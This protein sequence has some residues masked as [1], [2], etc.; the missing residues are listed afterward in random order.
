MS[1]CK[2]G[3]VEFN[4]VSDEIPNV[5]NEITDRPVEDIGAIVDNIKNKPLILSIQGV[6]TGEDASSKLQ[7]LREYAREKEIIDYVG[8]NAIG[9]VAIE[10]ISTSHNSMNSQGFNFEITLKQI[11]I[12]Q[13]ELIDIQAPDPA[14][15]RAAPVAT[16][17]KEPSDKGVQPPEPKRI[18]IEALKQEVD[19][20]V[21][22]PPDVTGRARFTTPLFEQF[23][24]AAN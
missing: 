13:I 9:K 16:Q 22:T 19:G 24:P 2:L 7:E 5:S 11:K 23:F 12:A 6:V 10:S 17:T 21:E 8:R 3:A 1:L 20:R 14:V 15:P 4:A 18:D